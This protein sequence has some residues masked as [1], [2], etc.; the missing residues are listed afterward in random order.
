MLHFEVGLLVSGAAVFLMIAAQ[1]CF[2]QKKFF[3]KKIKNT[4]T[5]KDGKLS[6]LSPLNT[7]SA[8]DVLSE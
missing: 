3:E 8:S 5:L 7:F 4:I 1:I 2:N 6:L